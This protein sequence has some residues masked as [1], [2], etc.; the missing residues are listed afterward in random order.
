MK[1]IRRARRIKAQGF[2]LAV[3]A[4]LAPA[5]LAA[6]PP[7]APAFPVVEG[8]GEKTLHVL[9]ATDT[10]LLPSGSCDAAAP[11]EGPLLLSCRE[12]PAARLSLDT[13][14]LSLERHRMGAS[15]ELI[16]MRGP[17]GSGYLEGAAYAPTATSDVPFLVIGAARPRSRD[18]V[19]F[20]VGV[21]ATPHDFEGRSL[22]GV[23][24][25][26]LVAPGNQHGTERG[27]G[28]SGRFELEWREDGA[29]LRLRP[30][31]LAPAKVAP[32]PSFAPVEAAGRISLGENEARF[33]GEDAAGRPVSLAWRYFADPGQAAG[34]LS[35][36][37]DQVPTISASPV[38]ETAGW[39]GFFVATPGERS[40]EMTTRAAAEEPAPASAGTSQGSAGS[41]L[42]FD[43]MA[44]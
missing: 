44:D 39:M 15:G 13:D 28:Q 12:G 40:A 8:V 41:S 26:R 32:R 20:V 25:M 33:A 18:P 9:A 30:D 31:P 38:E 5:T 23:W 19:D 6:A 17:L 1:A 11:A 10:G 37:I 29:T 3:V 42:T 16:L 14:H 34:L 2:V 21:P 7:A 43:S 24:L 22:S 27:A 4:A 36:S 35:L